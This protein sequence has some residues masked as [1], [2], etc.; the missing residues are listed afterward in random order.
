[1]RQIGRAALTVPGF[2]NNSIFDL[3]HPQNRDDCFQPYHA[4]REKF[5]DRGIKFDT[6]DLVEA[7][8]ALFEV[9][10]DVQSS[11][12]SNRRYLLLLETP[13]IH[14]QNGD[15]VNWTTYRKVFTWDDELVDD[16][17]FI[18][19]NFPN[20][21]RFNKEPEY[22][23]RPGFCCMISGNRAAKIRDGRTLYKKRVDV[24]RWFEENAPRDF[25][26]F[27]IDWD[28]PAAREGLVGKFHRRFWLKFRQAIR[29][30]P[31]PSYRG[32]VA[33]KSDVLSTTRFAICFENVRDLPGYITEKIFD[34]F[35]SGCVP[36]YLGASNIKDHIPSDC[37]IDW[38]D[39]GDISEVYRF[40]KNI[41]DRDFN[42]YQIRI[43]E[44]L[45]S[46][47]AFPFSSEYFA[48]T[49]VEAIMGDLGSQD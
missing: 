49:I 38:R 13:Q 31:F 3:R 28:I 12:T 32:R 16:N 37:F 41:S 23:H 9:H 29:V 8:T 48:E 14:P 30:K 34:C 40:L 33:R 11:Q 2:K 25:D 35:F 7:G 46:S 47:A 17:R 44:F 18:K 15:P 24:I 19:I 6:S 5:K 39:F 20:S 36:V 42:L 22:V 45:Q 26:L 1:L 10:M 21:I 4:L 43:R 27:G